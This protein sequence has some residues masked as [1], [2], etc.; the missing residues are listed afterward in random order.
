MKKLLSIFALL[1]VTSLAC[2]QAT[3]GAGTIQGTVTDP[4]GAVVS[5][6]TV[7]ITND[8]TG[9]VKIVSSN[10]GGQY[11]SGPIIPGHYTVE[12]AAP[13][14][15]VTRAKENVQ[16]GVVSNG[17]LKLSIGAGSAVVDVQGSD[18]RVDTAQSEVQ[19]VITAAQ[20][21]NLPI[22]GRNFLDLAQLEPGVQLQDGQDFDP[23]KAGYSS[24]SINGV[25]GRTARLSLDGQDI[26]DETVGTTTLN[27][28]S[29]SIDEAQIARSGLDLSTEITS[30][31]TV[32]VSTRSGT[33]KFHGQGYGAFRDARAGFAL[34]PG[35]IYAP[36]QRNAF[37]GGVGGPIIKDKLFFFVSSDRIKQDASAQLQL[38]DPFSSHSGSYDASFKDTYSAGRLDFNGPKGIHL[39]FRVGY[40]VNGV[41]GNGGYA[42]S[43][44]INR[45]NTP[46]YVGGADFATGKFTHQIRWSYLKFHNFIG[47]DSQGVYNPL[48]GVSL[49]GNGGLFTGPNLL[50]PQAT[51]QSDKQESYNG[52]YSL[53]SH[54]IRFGFSVNRIEGGGL[55]NFFG[56]SPFVTLSSKTPGG[57]STDTNPVDYPAFYVIFGN[58]EG[59][60]T[61]K[62]GFN[63]P[64]GGQNDWRTHAYVSDSWKAI[65][66]RLTVNYGIGYDRDTGRTD[67]DLAALPCADAV[68][69]FGSASPCTSGRL[70]DSLSPGLG[71]PVRQPNKN[72]GPSA[73]F[74]Y[75]LTGSGKTVIRGGLGLYYENS[76][77][78]NTLFDRPGK[79]KA[80]LF[81]AENYLCGPFGNSFALP[82]GTNLTSI[83]GI[84]FATLCKDPVSVSGPYFAQL[85]AQYQAASAAA[86]PAANPNYI[87]SVLTNSSDGYSIYAPG[88][89]SARSIQ[90]NIGVQHELWKGAVFTADY[91]RN[92][93]EHFQQAI[94]QNRVG[95]A[96][97]LNTT[98]AANAIAATLASLPG[99]PNQSASC[100]NST[101]DSAIAT[102]YG[103]YGGTNAAGGNYLTIADFA[104]NGLDSGNTYNGGGYPDAYKG[105]SVSTGAA[106]PGLNP[107]WG[108]LKVFYPIGRSVYNALQTN[109]RQQ[110]ANPIKGITNSN[111]EAS[112]TYSRF[113]STGGADQF[114]SPGVYD[115]DSPTAFKGPS[116]L[117]RT[118]QLSFGGFFNIKYGPQV[119]IVGH[120]FSSLPGNLALQED[121]TGA[122]G[123]IFRTDVTGDGTTGDLVPGTQPGAFMRSVKGSN[124]NRVID[125]YNQTSAGKL[126]PAGQAL[127]DSGLFTPNQLQELAA[128]TP[129][130]ARAP[131]DQVNNGWL[132]TFDMSL[133]Y[134]IH[135][136]FLGEGT[137]ISPSISFFN[138][139]NFAN[140]GNVGGTLQSTADLFSSNAGS[141]SLG[142]NTTEPVQRTPLRLNDG[143][144]SFAVGVARQTEYGLKLVF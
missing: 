34:S 57:S 138:L 39:F 2:G 53:K 77:F 86:G 92:V 97:T 63:L 68:A 48:P 100:D 85:Q 21:D 137:S 9:S 29:T 18:V 88:Y 128:V 79:L 132:R 11:T 126:T 110:R 17:S 3:T 19:G 64:G 144:G 4:T 108:N 98:A 37:G 129:A 8:G 76:I 118:H 90:M 70:L 6:A 120:I 135:L 96:R 74:A 140:F 104:S 72:I 119:G 24:V 78:N 124:I 80:G 116:G 60:F 55:A 13:G 65:P 101:I 62:S 75:D 117:D 54:Q 30:S 69:A 52:S 109:F 67:S 41:A 91:V 115:Y 125:S 130:I 143:T 127:V 25:F 36:F 50:A 22:N 112:Y 45:D 123:E 121:P 47:D 56:L 87:P 113:I 14:F 23:T 42:F 71:A 102:C 107:L 82:N 81:N 28:S 134:P 43:R 89:R 83:G 139:F 35:G 51:Y 40:E 61:E 26:S 84:S 103:S 58:G 93:G 142:P 12:I 111:F 1:T 141:V 5:G 66:G 33:N 106:F 133:S 136:K 94:D 114:F 15:S 44:Y 99:L 122:P 73:G 10:S 20:I 49:S 38:G 7:T 31:G 46:A 95:A 105:H 32:I 16:I 59:F 27:V 131:S